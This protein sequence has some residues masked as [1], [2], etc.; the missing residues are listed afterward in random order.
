M[1]KIEKRLE[2]VI[3]HSEKKFKC[4]DIFEK[5]LKDLSKKFKTRFELWSN[6]PRSILDKKYKSDVVNIIIG[7]SFRPARMGYFRKIF[8]E[9]FLND[10]VVGIIQPSYEG[11]VVSDE[12]GQ[13][14]AEVIGNK[15]TILF[16]MDGWRLEGTEM[17]FRKIIEQACGWIF[18][19]DQ[20]IKNT[21]YESQKEKRREIFIKSIGHKRKDARKYELFIEDIRK[22]IEKKQAELI[23][24]R[25]CLRDY[26]EKLDSRNGYVKK[27]NEIIGREYDLIMAMP[28]TKDI[29]VFSDSVELFTNPI[30]KKY[31]DYENIEFVMGEFRI[32]IKFF[33]GAVRIFNLMELNKKIDRQHPH[34]FKDG[35]PCL[36]NIKEAIPLLMFQNELSIA[37]ELLYKHLEN[38]DL[39]D[40][41][42]TRRFFYWPIKDETE[43]EYKTRIKLYEKM[44]KQAAD[45]KLEENPLPLF[46]KVLAKIYKN[47]EMVLCRR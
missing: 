16:P 5:V 26:E 6:C 10:A 24:L 29:R 18:N 19:A 36:G 20:E 31:E 39:T 38:I 35:V 46:N 14:L 23:S 43:K 3:I 37:V 44:L 27:E 21:Y 28:Q 15:I 22:D 33:S 42:A 4:A 11:F 45:P 25:H 12:D 34:V 17:I 30:V 40:H 2:N 7:V 41:W 13:E 32:Q 8:G 1:K 9:V 47:K